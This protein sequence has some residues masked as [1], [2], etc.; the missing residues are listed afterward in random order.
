MTAPAPKR[1]GA[2]RP[3]IV[4]NFGFLS[5]GETAAK[6]LTFFAFT[7]LGRMLGP[8]DYGNLEFALAVMVFF[9]LVVELGLGVWGARELAAGREEPS[10]L[11]REVAAIRLG[12][13]VAAAAVLVALALFVID[14]TPEVTLLLVAFALSLLL[15]P[16]LLEWF[17]QGHDAMHWVALA[18]IVRRGTFALLVFAFLTPETPLFHVGIYECLSVGATVLFC[19]TVARAHFGAFPGVPRARLRALVRRAVEAAPIG[20]SDIGWALLWYVA[21]VILY[22]LGETI[23]TGWF[24]ASHRAALAL[25]TFV[26]LYFFNL[27]P[28]IS[29][30]VVRPHEVLLRLME[31]SMLVSTWGS[32]FV[33][34]WLTGMAPLLLPLAYGE[35]FAGAAIPFAILVWIA[36]VT[37]ISGHYRYALVAYNLQRW[38]LLWTTVSAASAGVAA[39]FLIPAWGASGAA[40]A[41]LGANAICLVLVYVSV[42]RRIVR[43]PF[44]GQLLQPV[45]AALVASVPFVLP[46]A[47]NLWWRGIAS[48]VIYALIFLVLRWRDLPEFLSYLPIG[49]PLQA[50]QQARTE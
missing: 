33:A 11:L 19:L 15:V 42:R 4:R 8:G 9:S 17:F 38:L 13:A 12:L 50:P 6:V 18:A 21:T 49:G 28:A 27:L 36:P 7:Y 35:E 2:A 41:L 43:I 23:E 45:A 40:V 47:L 14:G 44:K 10:E 29:R 1:T 37:M 5:A 32:V 46:G 3:G 20:L 16:G 26:W 25:H 48:G 34:Y 39:L 24:G 22:F 30:C 31:R